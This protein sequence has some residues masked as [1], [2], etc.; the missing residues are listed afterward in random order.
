MGGDEK[1]TGY[2]FQMVEGDNQFDSAQAATVAAQ[3]LDNGD[4]VASVGPAGS[5]QV[6]AAGRTSNPE[7]PSGAG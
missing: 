5:D 1:R 3:F 7:K 6:A 2:D 4:M